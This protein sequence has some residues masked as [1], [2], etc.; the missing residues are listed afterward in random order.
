MA[1]KEFFTK[2]GVTV[3]YIG[4]LYWSVSRTSWVSRYWNIS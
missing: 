4:L 3:S 1:V 2:Q